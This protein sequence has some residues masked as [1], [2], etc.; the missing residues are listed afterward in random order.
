[1]IKD[2]AWNFDAASHDTVFVHVTDEE[3]NKLTLEIERR[4]GE[5]TFKWLL[6]QSYNFMVKLA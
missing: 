5:R 4:R 2:V 3:G 6:R 1:M